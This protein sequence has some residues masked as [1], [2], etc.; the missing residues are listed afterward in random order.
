[1]RNV[2]NN[3]ADADGWGGLSHRPNTPAWVRHPMR[4]GWRD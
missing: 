4:E 1:M 3:I 2:L